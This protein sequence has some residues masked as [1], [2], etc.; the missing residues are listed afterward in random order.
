M[1]KRG[2]TENA[3]QSVIVN[4]AKTI[5]TTDPRFDCISGSCLNDS[6]TAYITLRAENPRQ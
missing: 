3:T 2:W 1:G 4:P 5:V 6:A